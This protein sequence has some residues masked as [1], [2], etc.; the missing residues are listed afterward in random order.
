[1]KVDPIDYQRRNVH[2]DRPHPQVVLKAYIP[3]RFSL[4]RRRIG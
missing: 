1:M 3:G 4:L 2:F